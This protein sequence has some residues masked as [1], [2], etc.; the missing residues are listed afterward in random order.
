MHIGS[1]KVL[2][3]LSLLLLGTGFEVVLNATAF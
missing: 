1:K 3:G 2:A